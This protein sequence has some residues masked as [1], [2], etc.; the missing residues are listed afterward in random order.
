MINLVQVSGVLFSTLDS[1]QSPGRYVQATFT[2]PNEVQILRC[3]RN[4]IHFRVT[5]DIEVEDTVTRNEI[6][7]LLVTGD[8]NIIRNLEIHTK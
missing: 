1:I 2:N 7:S 4:Q 6:G 3:E 5:K 8:N